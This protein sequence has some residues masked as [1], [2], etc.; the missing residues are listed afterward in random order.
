MYYAHVDDI[1]GVKGNPDA[2]YATRRSQLQTRVEEVLMLVDSA[3]AYS[4][5]GMDEEEEGK[6]PRVPAGMATP[7]GS[8]A[9]TTASATGEKDTKRKTVSVR[10]RTGKHGRQSASAKAATAASDEQQSAK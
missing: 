2:F 4:L 10:T 6:V 1:D 9:L 5:E 8:S 3:R 7:S